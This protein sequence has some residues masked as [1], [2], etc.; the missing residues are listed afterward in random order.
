MTRYANTRSIA[1]H[2]AECDILTK[3]RFRGKNAWVLDHFATSDRTASRP[4][5]N[6]SGIIGTIPVLKKQD[7][8]I[9]LL[10]QVGNNSHS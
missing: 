7:R 4:F 8:I 10:I 6:T 9:L 3:A 2:L 1:I 5:S